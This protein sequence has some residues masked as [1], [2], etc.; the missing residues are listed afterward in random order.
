[1]LKTGSTSCP[2]VLTRP[3]CP[4]DVGL[5]LRTVPG[6]EEGKGPG[7]AS[8]NGEPLLGNETQETKFLGGDPF[9]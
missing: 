8:Q 5:F 1:M 7:A 3:N 6:Q 4:F 2:L 9:G